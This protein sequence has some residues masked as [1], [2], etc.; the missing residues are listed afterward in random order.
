MGKSAALPK[1]SRLGEAFAYTLNQ[2][3]DLCYY[4]DDVL[5]EP[6]NKW[7]N[8][9]YEPSALVK[10]ITSSSAP[11]TAVSEEPCYMDLSEHAGSMVSMR[12]PTFVTS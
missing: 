12:K 4:C 6:D 10:K 11:S 7:Q 2:W 1:K 3:D 9:R 5:A 8:A